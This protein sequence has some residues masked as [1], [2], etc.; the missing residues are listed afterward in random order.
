MNAL[1]EEGI[2]PNLPED[3]DTPVHI[4]TPKWMFEY[5]RKLPSVGMKQARNERVLYI[6]RALSSTEIPEPSRLIM[7]AN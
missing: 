7:T 5:L 6:M 2:L 4:E 1:E 3:E